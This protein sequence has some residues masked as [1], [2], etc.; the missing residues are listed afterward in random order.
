M[1]HGSDDIEHHDFAAEGLE[2]SPIRVFKIGRVRL[3]DYEDALSVFGHE[4][5]QAELS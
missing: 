3:A 1:V 2:R 5:G 4:F